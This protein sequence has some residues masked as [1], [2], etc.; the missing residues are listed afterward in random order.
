M[1]EID[2]EVCPYGGSGIGT[3]AAA[4]RSAGYSELN[5]RRGSVQRSKLGGIRNWGCNRAVKK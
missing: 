3:A 4:Q 1:E 2:F 5:R